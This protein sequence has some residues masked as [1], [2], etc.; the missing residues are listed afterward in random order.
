[1]DGLRFLR[2]MARLG[3]HVVR[4]HGSHRVLQH[5]GTGATLTV[6]FHGTIKRSFAKKILGQAGL[7][8][9]EFLEEF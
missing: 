7:S 9:E 1:M 5:Q 4:Q 3:W 6:A 8:E 2:A